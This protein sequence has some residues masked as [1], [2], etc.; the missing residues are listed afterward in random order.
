MDLPPQDII[1]QTIDIYKRMIEKLEETKIKNL[2]GVSP[3][4]A[5]ELGIV[6]TENKIETLIEKMEKQIDLL[7]GKLKKY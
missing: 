7:E 5:K 2:V 1:K 6:Q 3:R 4:L